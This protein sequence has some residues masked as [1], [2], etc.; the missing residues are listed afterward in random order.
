MDQKIWKKPEETNDSV[1]AYI[2]EDRKQKQNNRK[3][4]ITKHNVLM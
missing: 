1:I 4:Q 2:C 3:P